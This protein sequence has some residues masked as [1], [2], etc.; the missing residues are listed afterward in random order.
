MIGV[1][2]GL[3]RIIEHGV[4][5]ILVIPCNMLVLKDKYV[6]NSIR[7]INMEDEILPEIGD[8]IIE[9]TDLTSFICINTYEVVKICE[10]KYLVVERLC[11]GDMYRYMLKDFVYN[12]NGKFR[13]IK[14]HV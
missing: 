11:N 8:K 1:A 13:F 2:N 10:D 9:T 7:R 14:E 3:R 12:I 5:N 4:K 6:G